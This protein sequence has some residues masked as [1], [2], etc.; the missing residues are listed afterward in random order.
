MEA[1]HHRRASLEWMKDWLWAVPCI[2]ARFGE[3]GNLQTAR[4][5]ILEAFPSFGAA[6]SL[7]LLDVSWPE[8]RAVV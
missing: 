6:S 1:G 2:V 7:W 4:H 3:E 8:K 5:M